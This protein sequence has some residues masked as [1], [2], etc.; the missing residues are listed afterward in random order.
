MSWDSSRII[1]PFVRRLGQGA[2]TEHGAVNQWPRV[3]R[4]AHRN[5]ECD[6]RVWHSGPASRTAPRYH[7]LPAS[8]KFEQIPLVVY[9]ETLAIAVKFLVQRLI[10]RTEFELIVL[11][12]RLVLG[13]QIMEFRF[14]IARRYIPTPLGQSQRSRVEQ[15][16]W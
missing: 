10:G 15:R 7:G 14:Y 1:A 6:W 4:R 11:Q 13:A 2:W 16:N 3:R 5:L 8:D 12:P 9:R